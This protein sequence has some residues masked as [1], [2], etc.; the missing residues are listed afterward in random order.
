M[1]LDCFVNIRG[2]KM[3]NA[4]DLDKGFYKFSK[5]S[6]RLLHETKPELLKFTLDF[7]QRNQVL[8]NSGNS[9]ELAH[10]IFAKLIDQQRD[11]KQ[12]RLNGIHEMITIQKKSGELLPYDLVKSWASDIDQVDLQE[13]ERSFL[14]QAK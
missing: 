2:T 13:D 12:K 10:D 14:K 1:I 7:L 11:A 9:F 5:R 8:R 4:F 3:P 6:P